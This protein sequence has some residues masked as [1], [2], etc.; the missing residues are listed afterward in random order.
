MP[1]DGKWGFVDQ[2]GRYLINPQFYSPP[3]EGAAYDLHSLALASHEAYVFSE[4]LALVRTKSEWVYVD[5]LGRPVIRKPEIRSARRFS[6]GL[7][8]VYVDGKW[9]YMNQA[10]EMVIPARFLYPVNFRDGLVV[11]MDQSRKKIVIDRQGKRLLPQYQIESQFYDGVAASRATFR[12][13]PTSEAEARMFGLVDTA[14]RMLF[15]PMYDAVGRFGSGMCPVLVGS[16]S[17]NPLLH[18]NPVLPTENTGGKWGFVNRIGQF[19]LNPTYDEAKGFREGIAAVKQGGLWGYMDTNGSMITGFEFR[20]VD[21][22]D[23]GLAVVQLSA[24][25]SEYDGKF[26]YVNREGEVLWIERE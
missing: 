14:G 6:E 24:F 15:E 25:H 8:N 2:Q 17:G 16:K 26:A 4:G 21:Y 7:A 19:V 9:G 20:W 12:G 11:V 23:N 22:F 10:G 5:T 18:P 3:V 13:E 1:V